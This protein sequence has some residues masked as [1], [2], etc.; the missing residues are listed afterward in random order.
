MDA[1]S[2]VPK[3][4]PEGQVTVTLLFWTRPVN[5]MPYCL[6]PA[7][8]QNLI[9]ALKSIGVSAQIYEDV[10]YQGWYLKFNQKVPWVQF[11]N[12]GAMNAGLLANYFNHGVEP[13]VG[14]PFEAQL[15]AD[16]AS[17]AA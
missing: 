7:D 5:P 12:G 1:N 15:L 2:Y 8:G 4:L 14:S 11:A 13:F 17:R 10:P 9:D 6:D 16:V 3:Y